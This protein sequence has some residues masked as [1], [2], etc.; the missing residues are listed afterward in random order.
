MCTKNLFAYK[1]NKLAALDFG[2][3]R[4]CNHQTLQASNDQAKQPDKTSTKISDLTVVETNLRLLQPMHLMLLIN[5][6]T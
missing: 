4:K 1:Q 2:P 5:F 6:T 3:G